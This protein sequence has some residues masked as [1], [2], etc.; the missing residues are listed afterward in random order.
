MTIRKFTLDDYAEYIHWWG[1]NPPELSSLPNI[2][3]ITDNAVGFLA[4]TDTD[5][6]IFTFW[7]GNPQSKPREIYRDFVEIINACKSS[8]KRMNKNYVFCYTSI[9]GMIKLLESQDFKNNEGHLVYEV[10]HG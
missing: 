8:A 7:Q 1:E 2:G 4:N 6:M 5:F 3:Y 9:N 10:N